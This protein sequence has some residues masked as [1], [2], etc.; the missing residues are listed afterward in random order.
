MILLRVISLRVRSFLFRSFSLIKETNISSFLGFNLGNRLSLVTFFKLDNSYKCFLIAYKSLSCLFFSSADYQV[1][2]TNNFFSF[3]GVLYPIIALLFIFYYDLP[4]LVTCRFLSY[5]FV[6]AGESCKLQ[7][8]LMVLTFNIFY[9]FRA[10]IYSK[11][12]PKDIS[13]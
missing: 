3:V 10:I 9:L 6:T 8:F 5:P 11:Y 12:F 1:F 7:C 4:G 13:S 2:T